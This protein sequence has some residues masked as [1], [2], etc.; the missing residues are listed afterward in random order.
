NNIKNINDIQKIIPIE[1][2]IITDDIGCIKSKLM[3]G[4]AIIQI[5]EK[6]KCCAL[7]NISNTNAGMRVQNNVENEYSVIGPR[8][9]F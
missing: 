7:V 3:T 5:T 6:D 8:I 1:D 2:I 4:Y 9:G